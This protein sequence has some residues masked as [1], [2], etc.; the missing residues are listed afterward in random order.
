MRRNHVTVRAVIQAACWLALSAAA[1][2]QSSI[3]GVVTDSAGAAIPAASV[4]VTNLATGVSQTLLSNDAG[5]YAVPLLGAGHYRLECAASGFTAQQRPEVPLEVGQTARVD[6][7]LS[8]GAV[9]EQIEVSG[10][11]PLIQS[12]TSEVGQVIDSKRI[13][14]MPLNGRN[15]LELAQFSVGVLP[16]GN[17]AGATAQ[18]RKAAF[19]QWEF[20]HTRTWWFWMEAT[21]APCCSE[22]P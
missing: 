7:Q 21:T 13:I 10:R 14:E 4:K 11:A 6:F 2:G 8:V 3:Q 19:C 12:E 20:R 22:A 15:Y 1:Y 18:Q 5:L 16:A 9:T 17:S